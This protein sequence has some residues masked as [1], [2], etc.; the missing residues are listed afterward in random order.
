MIREE[1]ATQKTAKLL[2]EA[3]F[4]CRCR[5]WYECKD[6]E[7]TEWGREHVFFV[8]IQYICF[9]DSSLKTRCEMIRFTIKI[10]IFA[11]K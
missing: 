3:G 9:F 6:S 7:P 8:S 11:G 2:K 10:P 4:D 5:K 1:Y